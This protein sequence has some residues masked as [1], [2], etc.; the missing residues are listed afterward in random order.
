[1]IYNDKN[2]S[3]ILIG[4]EIDYRFYVVNT[5]VH[6]YNAGYQ[7]IDMFPCMNIPAMLNTIYSFDRDEFFKFRY[8]D[9]LKNSYKNIFLN[10]TRHKEPI[11]MMKLKSII[12][13][14]YDTKIKV[15][16]EEKWQTFSTQV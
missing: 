11:S 8:E 15:Y 10:I 6:E 7:F 16:N 12:E 14:I 2:Y 1:M 13:E 9:Y 4:I 5:F 3:K